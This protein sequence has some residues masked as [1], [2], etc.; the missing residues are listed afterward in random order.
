VTVDAV[1][2]PATITP[3]EGGELIMPKLPVI[4]NVILALW[5]IDPAVPV[6][7]TV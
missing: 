4:V 1:A 7:V 2:L 6:I 3:G 5:T